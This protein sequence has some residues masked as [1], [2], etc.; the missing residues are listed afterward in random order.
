MLKNILNFLIPPYCASCDELLDSDSCLCESCLLSLPWTENPSSNQNPILE[1][2]TGR[3]RIEKANALFYFQPGGI[4]QDL[5]HQLK[6]KGR[7]DIGIKL[8]MLASAQFK[9]S[10]IFEDIDAIVPIPL[11]RK[12]EKKRGFNQSSVIA[13]GLSLGLQI[14]VNE[15][16][17][18][19]KEGQSQ[20]K[21]SR[22]ERFENTLDI[23]MW[24]PQN[25]FRHILLIDDVITTGGTIISAVHS[26]Q[27]TDNLKISVFAVATV[28]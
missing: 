4:I 27:K 5:L 20:T 22:F 19:I 14:P 10:S 18:R 17:V 1:L 24:L 26:I 2:F 23:F 21:K 16:L 6:Y 11:H 12:K 28:L 3:E 8:G 13:K 9:D 7:S 15:T 25:Q